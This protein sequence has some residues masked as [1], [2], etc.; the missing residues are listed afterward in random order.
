MSATTT[1]L[2]DLDLTGV[3]R[4]VSRNA[5]DR[6]QDYAR[7]GNVRELEWDP[8][9]YALAATVIGHGAAYET[10][11][12]FDEDVDGRLVFYDGECSCP[13]GDNCK[14]VAAVVIAAGLGTPSGQRGD[15]SDGRRPAAWGAAA[16]T[17]VPGPPA[18]ERSLRA[19]AA[20]RREPAS[21]TGLA[22]ELRLSR[23]TYSTQ[24]APQLMA[25]LMR[26]GARGGWVNGSLSWSGLDAWNVQAAGYRED[27]LT[28]ARELY[29]VHRLRDAH[30]SY[31]FYGS[32]SDRRI[33]LS[34]CESPQLWS[35]LDE[36][37]RVGLP[38]IH[39]QASLGEVP[40]VRAGDVVLDVTRA[41]DGIEVSAV[42]RVG[43][44]A[45]E[46]LVPVRLVGR[47]GHGV[48]CAEREDINAARAP[49]EWRLHLVRLARPAVAQ[50]EPL[51]LAGERLRIPEADVPRFAEDLCL[52]LR[53]VVPVI[54]SDG[55]FVP[56]TV[57][58]PALVLRVR[59]HPGA[60]SD[61]AWEWEYEVGGLPRRV[62][63]SP[64]V[65]AGFRDL[66]SERALLQSTSADA[67]TLKAIG[68]LDDAGLPVHG[69]PLSVRGLDLLELCA[70][71]F[72]RLDKH[73]D[74][75]L[76]VTG[77]PP[78][79][80]DVGES[81]QIG[82]STGEIAG[83]HDWF[84]L[85]VT[86][87]VEGRQVPFAEV[88]TALALGQ[89]RMLLDDGTH[90]SL[91]DP[92]L[93]Q[94]RRLIEEA[95]ALVDAPPG[96]PLRISRYHADLWSELVAL[97]VV[98]EQADRWQRIVTP[99]LQL[100]TLPSHEVPAGLRAELRPYQRDGFAWL[101]TLWELEL[102]G[103]LADDMGLGKTLQTLALICH[104][105]ERDPDGGPFLVVTPTSVAPNWATEAAR[106]APE[107]RA[108]VMLGTLARSA[109]TIEQV[110]NCDV[111]ITTY[112]LFRLEIDAYRRVPWAG[113][114]LDEAQYVKN[115]RGK[116]YRCA[117]ELDAPF[118]LAI[119]GTPMENNLMELWAMLS[120]TA[121]GLFADPARFAAHYARPIERGSDPER[122]ARL[123]RRVKPLV[124]R[125][126]KELVAAEL[127]PKQEQTVVV[128]LHPR[129]RKL[130]DT[131]LQRE[132][133]E[134]A[135][136]AR[137]LRPQPLHDPDLDHPPAPAQSP[138]RA[139]RRRTA[140]DPVRKARQ[141]WSSSSTKSSRAATGHS[142][143]A[144]SRSS[145]PRCAS[146][147]TRSASITATWTGAPAGAMKCS[148]A[149]A[150]GDA[151]VFLISLKAGGVGLN[152]T[153]AD[154]CF[155]LDPWWNPAT[156]A[157]AID[158]T[159]RIGQTRPVNVY[160]LIARDTIEEKVRRARR[161]Q[162]EAVP[163]RDGRRRS[164]RPR[165]HRR[166]HPRPARVRGEGLLRV[167]RIRAV[168]IV[169]MAADRRRLGAATRSL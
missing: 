30:S 87:T 146:A 36:A 124:K 164:V 68:L 165:R 45:A 152:L 47:S 158:R 32:S 121:P 8:D 58:G 114:L 10:V 19:L 136:A 74:I 34:S 93:E 155:L 42:L 81:L 60:V 150:S 96:A 6:G 107:L 28:L 22:I 69:P 142:C 143:S 20:V 132:R 129:H 17:P 90:F 111:L 131:H 3:Q 122:L 26:P 18:W 166:R 154:Y 13:V 99:L 4:A 9:E 53:H 133:A 64:D 24:G 103:I 94:L 59:H 160:R 145:S 29:A 148:T 46:N 147:S 61:L 117:R 134:G 138:P 12:F 48:V 89:S 67:P 43:G 106:F 2:S 85:G 141:R 97:G 101:S 168:P 139:G 76:A 130:Y 91:R 62:P 127:P 118:K 52:A 113:L 31:Y 126:T 140:H 79:F 44:D 37:P 151:P 135:G 95:N 56:P 109:R 14:H 144:S 5:F 84:D 50:L 15:T 49:E 54:S 40:P 104:A 80:R 102:G 70:E 137:R 55:S 21:G 33:D 169:P 88:F 38:L 65:A 86:I 125:R 105:R 25:R 110:A 66:A 100:D 23:P 83:E 120:L 78:D 123:R 92:R 75:H 153:E 167:T 163:W 112:A 1:D 35:L 72:P 77:T 156:E 57:S 41:G 149:S 16:P 159:H 161:V 82:V 63:V 119:T 98:T 7:H 39:A 115:H 11:A 128:D 27:H 157:Q 116:T 73:P 71:T 108:E 51:L 162:G